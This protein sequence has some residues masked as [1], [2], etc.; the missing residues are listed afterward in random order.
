MKPN[1]FQDGSHHHGKSLNPKTKIISIEKR[2]KKVNK[3]SKNSGI[4]KI[5][6]FPRRY[7]KED[8]LKSCRSIVGALFGSCGGWFGV[9]IFILILALLFVI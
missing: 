1:N 7:G 4:A 8:G 3:E 5:I 2:A 6:T 9:I